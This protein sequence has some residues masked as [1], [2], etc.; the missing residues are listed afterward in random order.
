MNGYILVGGQSRRMGSDKSQLTIQGRSL[1]H[2]IM[3][4]LISAGCKEV[5]LV[6]KKHIPISIPQIAEPWTEHHPL[7]GVYT[8]LDHCTDNFCIITPCDI[9]FVSI[10]TYQTLIAQS[11]T[12][13]LSTKSKKLQYKSP[14]LYGLAVRTRVFLSWGTPNGKSFVQIQGNERNFTTPAHK[15][16]ET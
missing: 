8:S 11:A 5:F 9:P 4:K 6:G 13:V 10:P 14:S 12:T 7:Y 2:I 16:I 15:L 3:Q 1:C